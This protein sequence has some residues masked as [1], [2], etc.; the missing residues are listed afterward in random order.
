[1]IH[2]TPVSLCCVT[3]CCWMKKRTLLILSLQSKQEI[4]R[5]SARLRSTKYK[6]PASE[7]KVS[8]K[9]KGRRHIFKL[10]NV[11]K[12]SSMHRVPCILSH[13]LDIISCVSC[14]IFTI[15]TLPK[16]VLPM[17]L[18][19]QPLVILKSFQCSFLN[20]Q[21]KHQNL[22]PLLSH[23]NQ[24]FIRYVWFHFFH[25]S[26]PCQSC[27]QL[28]ATNTRLCIGLSLCRVC[29]IRQEMSSK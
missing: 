18:D 22:F 2:S 6:A 21:L 9:G 1:M 8:T 16:V 20:S 28:H 3:R 7:K 5:R 10:K 24:S 29:I 23:Q 26:T 25:F 13:S 17:P 11:S 27:Q 14:G 15:K 4:H 12:Y 19:T